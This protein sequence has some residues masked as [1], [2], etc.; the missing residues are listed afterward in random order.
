MCIGEINQ[1]FNRFKIG[2]IEEYIEKSKNK[3][4]YLFE[5]AIVCNLILS[6]KISQNKFKNFGLNIGIAFQIR[7]DLLNILS[8]DTTKPS[9]NDIEE[10]IYNAPIIYSGNPKDLTSG[11]EKH[12]VC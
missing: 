5:T 3:T 12:G 10:G 1:N 2:T 8:I 6:Q 9:N 7:D 11:I 4:G